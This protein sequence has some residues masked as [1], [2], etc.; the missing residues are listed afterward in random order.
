MKLL[1]VILCG[2]LA[3]TP[4]VTDAD[5]VA[6]WNGI[7]LTL[8][9]DQPPP[10]QNRYAA[11][12]QLAVFEAVNAVTGDYEPYLGTITPAPGASA[13]A[14][15]A[16]AA[17][18]V[19]RHYFPDHADRLDASLAESLGGIPDGPARD[20]GIAV[21]EAAAAAMIRARADD[22]SEPP[23]EHLPDSDAPGVWQLT[24]DC[25]ASGGLFAHWP[26]VRPFALR[27]G[28]Q[29][30]SDP[31]P[32]LTS[33]AYTWAYR[34]V[35][36]VG[37][38]ESR[39]RSQNRTDVVRMYA[40]LSDAVL[41]NPIAVEIAAARRSSLADTARTLALL[42]MALSDGG[43]AV[44]DTKYHYDF[45]RPETA[46]VNAH[47]DGNRKTHPDPS[48]EPFIPAPCFPSYPSGHAT[49]SYAA[50][51][52]LE[53]SFGRGRHRVTVTS[54]ALPGVVLKY[55]RLRQITADIDDARVY[56]GI[57]FR[58]DQQEGARQGTA[59]GAFIAEHSLRRKPAPPCDGAQR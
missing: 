7:M 25:P 57:H 14:A 46:I 29:F 12:T 56:G 4:A 38:R 44:L 52:V 20:G 19:L 53:R 24:P 34:E 45:W 16:S 39:E 22:G 59:I 50:R 33:G 28:D 36:A 41:W 17:H 37:A 21:G 58:F 1:T 11:I 30:R 32:K 5:V 40:L 54:P 55:T 26:H 48:F 8:I 18:G 3:W 6:D 9:G 43:V 49:T 31:P 42:N 2:L 47:A 23:E 15:A 10:Y 51:A 13:R 35:K 27:S